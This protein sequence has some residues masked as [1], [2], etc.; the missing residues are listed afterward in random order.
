MKSTKLVSAQ[1]TSQTFSVETI[2]FLMVPDWGK[3]QTMFVY[4]LEPSVRLSVTSFLTN[5][6]LLGA[7]LFKFV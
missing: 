6:L 2:L 7:A 5:L 1:L 3:A 4:P